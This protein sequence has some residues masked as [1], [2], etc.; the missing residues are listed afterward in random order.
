LLDRG[1]EG[2]QIRVKDGRCRFHPDH[3]PRDVSKRFS[4]L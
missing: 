4:T 1:V 3:S 2:I